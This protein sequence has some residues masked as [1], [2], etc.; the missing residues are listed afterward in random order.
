MKE[1]ARN[2]D[3]GLHQFRLGSPETALSS[4][5]IAER[6]SADKD[7]FCAHATVCAS[8]RMRVSLLSVQLISFTAILDRHV[9]QCLSRCRM[10]DK[11]ETF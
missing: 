9:E 5:N 2:N 10:A 3:R 11:I 6:A 7:Y 4:T 8:L 1:E